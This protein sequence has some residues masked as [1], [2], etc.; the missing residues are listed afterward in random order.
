MTEFRGHI[1]EII[2]DGG[3]VDAVALGRTLELIDIWEDL[4]VPFVNLGVMSQLEDERKVAGILSA[5][6]E[7]VDC[8]VWSGS[9]L[10]LQ[11]RS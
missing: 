9:C 1:L 3:R 11:P 7:S 5:E 2:R 10:R 4:D 6:R 8:D